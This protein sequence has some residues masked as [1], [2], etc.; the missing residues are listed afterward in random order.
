MSLE[1]KLILHSFLPNVICAIIIYSYASISAQ[2]N[3]TRWTNGLK[4]VI[5]SIVVLQFMIAP[6]VDHLA[7]RKINASVKNFKNHETTVAERTELLEQLIHL[8]IVTEALTFLFFS[9]AS[10]ALFYYFDIVENVRTGL[11]ILILFEC[12]F[13]SFFAAI[14]ADDYSHNIISKYAEEVVIAGVD[15]RYISKRH[16]FGKS[17]L[18]QSIFFVILPIVFS[19]IISALIVIIGY[20][21]VDQR[22]YHEN[23]N[24]Q[25]ARMIWT[26]IFNFTV[27]ITMI[28]FFYQKIY[29]RNK[30]LTK[31]FN[32]MIETNLTY[33]KGI[34]TDLSNELSYSHYLI[35]EM[36][37][38][39]R[40]ILSKS[41]TI[42]DKI[43]S[44]IQELTKMSNETESTSVQQSTGTK[45]IVST[46]ED[47][48]RLN[49]NIENS[50]GE[51]AEL[52][53]QT[54]N[55]VSDGS[56]I[57]M[58]NLN[59]MNLIARANEIT[60]NG[61]RDLNT[62]IN[63]I[64][65]VVNIINSIADQT[66]IIAFNAELEATNV[67]DEKRN[68]KNVSNEIR[69]L[70]NNTMDSTKEIKERIT[71][72]QN[73]SANL[74]KSSQSSTYLI[75]QGSELSNSLKEKFQN[76]KSSAESSSSSADEIKYLIN[77]Q[78]IAFDQIVKT[79]QQISNGIQNFSVST[80]TV[81]DTTN[82]LQESVNR[83][84][85]IT[86]DE[87]NGENENE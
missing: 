30:N 52:A 82:I 79:L 25:I 85:N 49:H 44:S 4:L 74:I 63:S 21:P 76:I 22:V 43:N 80:K 72:I 33:T 60:I 64:W 46:M 13:G 32:K 2:L 59:K 10:F 36:I 71:E 3:F 5:A 9:F 53:Q 50:I 73:A 68:F 42:G 62:K 78:N 67:H 54:V 15:K 55:S 56:E 14:F 77:Q 11:S 23:A 87:Y 26:A 17:L 8:P 28:I 75:S 34:R 65:E 69:R 16:Y 29:S 47:A 84:K 57:L 18:S 27:Q 7:Y 35:N 61:I 37:S 19:T 41:T 39:F 24:S 40:S 86:N 58:N 20:F 81:I 83:L 38:I 48:A 51:V 12:I 1:K 45:E 66:K 31:I 70:A 6:I